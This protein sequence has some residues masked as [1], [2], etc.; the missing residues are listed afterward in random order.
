VVWTE[1]WASDGQ[2]LGET[3]GPTFCQTMCFQFPLGTYWPTV[4]DDTGEYNN[5][6]SF[7][8]FAWFVYVYNASSFN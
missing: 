5:E 7:V 4:S 1:H 3:A 2:L 8:I 6:V